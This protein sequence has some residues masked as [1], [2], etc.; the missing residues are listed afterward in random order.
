MERDGCGGCAYLTPGMNEL[1]K[2]YQDKVVF[3]NVDYMKVAEPVW[4][5]HI[6]QIPWLIIFRSNKVIDSFGTTVKNVVD[7]HIQKALAAME[8]KL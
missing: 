1:A 2:K 7:Q 3:L 8:P 4:D 5:Y 6:K